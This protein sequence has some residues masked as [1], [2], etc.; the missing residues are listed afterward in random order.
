MINTN[1]AFKKV[2]VYTVV[3][4]LD[5]FS[6]NQCYEMLFVLRLPSFPTFKRLCDLEEY[7]YLRSFIFGEMY[8]SANIMKAFKMTNTVADRIQAVDVQTV[9]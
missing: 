9:L 7:V 3:S 4:Q 6:V 5:Y 8:Q 2:F 1:G